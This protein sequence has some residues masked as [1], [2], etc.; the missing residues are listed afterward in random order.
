MEHNNYVIIRKTSPHNLFIFKRKIGETKWEN[1][2]RFS[3]RSENKFH[4]YEEQDTEYSF[5]VVS[6]IVNWRN[7]ASVETKDG[8]K[9]IC[10]F[11][12]FIKRDG[13]LTVLEVV[14]DIDNFSI[15]QKFARLGRVNI[16]NLSSTKC[17]SI[18]QNFHFAYLYSYQ[19]SLD[20]IIL[21][22]S[23]LVNDERDCERKTFI[24]TEGDV[25]LFFELY[26]NN[27][28]D[29]ILQNINVIK[30]NGEYKIVES[31]TLTF[32]DIFGEDELTKDKEI[33]LNKGLTSDR[34]E[35][36]YLQIV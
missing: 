1:V 29:P 6:V 32:Q 16:V 14:G 17:L 31:A 13:S 7:V 35:F 15:H 24:L 2:M 3:K 23:I 22:K 10:T 19:D 25:D 27:G 26:T 8:L 11:D 4:L 5:E 36:Y 33:F 12:D 21:R 30:N 18:H 9:K 34:K 20:S 28:G